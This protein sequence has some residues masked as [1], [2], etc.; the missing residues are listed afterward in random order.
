MD[1]HLLKKIYIDVRGIYRYT[2]I[3]N[4]A[5][6]YTVKFDYSHCYG[7]N[8]VYTVQHQMN[9]NVLVTEKGRFSAKILYIY[10]YFF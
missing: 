6:L 4:E 3:N 8:S 5:K 7:S 9:V 2:Q 10:I 1:V